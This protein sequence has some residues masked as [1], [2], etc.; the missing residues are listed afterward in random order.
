[1]EHEFHTF[2]TSG[3]H[4][5]LIGGPAKLTT[6]VEPLINSAHLL[7]SPTFTPGYFRSAHSP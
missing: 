1:M 5:V 2:R 7:S 4:L 3:V 6:P